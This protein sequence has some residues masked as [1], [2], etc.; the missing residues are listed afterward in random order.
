MKLGLEANSI[1]M[2][3]ITT[4]SFSF[5]RLS[6]VCRPNVRHLMF[7]WRQ[8]AEFELIVSHLSRMKGM[9][10][11]VLISYPIVLHPAAKP[12][13]FQVFQVNTGIY[14]T[15]ESCQKNII[16]TV[17]LVADIIRSTFDDL[18]LISTHKWS[19]W[20]NSSLDTIV[21]IPFAAIIISMCVCKLFY[22]FIIIIISFGLIGMNVFVSD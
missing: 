2:E 1:V 14:L 6:L 11:G 15:N 5:R 21:W 16:S 22:S 9:T 20:I 10:G 8:N 3:I 19:N 13:Q 18:M 4:G 17:S 7:D 12:I